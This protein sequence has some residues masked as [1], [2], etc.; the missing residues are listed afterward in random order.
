MGSAETE[1]VLD[2][3]FEH[4]KTLYKWRFSLLRRALC[5][6][7]CWMRAKRDG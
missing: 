6:W 4:L 7:R 3:I 2:E 5:V 1:A